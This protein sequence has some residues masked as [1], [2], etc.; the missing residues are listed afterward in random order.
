MEM[1]E[2]ELRCVRQA[3]DLIDELERLDDE[4]VVRDK[5]LAYI[6]Q[7][8]FDY[9]TITRLPE[10]PARLAPYMMLKAW[11]ERWLKLYDSRGYYRDDPV[12]RRCFWTLEPFFWSRVPCDVDLQPNSRR[13]MAEAGEHGMRDGFC[14]PLHD[15]N[16]LQ[17][18]VSMAAERIEIETAA[19]RALHLVSIYAFGA[20]ERIVRARR[21]KV[22][23]RLSRREREVLCWLAE[24][25]TAASVAETLNIAETTVHSHLQRARQKLGT[26][27]TVHTVVEALRQRQIRL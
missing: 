4:I 26:N 17:A 13:I 23:G 11:P 16:G 15:G 2:S 12:G 8:G 3:F 20:A 14:V 7:F 18:V 19:Q 9:F 22:T 25:R 21:P 5:L 24:G 10:P 6:G 1:T 27:N